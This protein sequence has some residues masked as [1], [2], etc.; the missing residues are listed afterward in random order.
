VAGLTRWQLGAIKGEVDLGKTL[1]M[2]RRPGLRF[3]WRTD[4]LEPGRK[5]VQTCVERPGASSG[6]T[7]TISLSD[8]SHGRTLVQLSDAGWR[9]DDPALPLCNTQLGEAL[10]RPCAYP[11]TAEPDL[12]AEYPNTFGAM[13]LSGSG[14]HCFL[15]FQTPNRQ[16]RHASDGTPERFDL[17]C[18]ERFVGDWQRLKPRM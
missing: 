8:E 2:E 4:Q 14:P 7:L 1:V 5:I 17:E 16:R 6:K 12:P 13:H 18:R 11:K 9:A 3:G 15:R 10:S